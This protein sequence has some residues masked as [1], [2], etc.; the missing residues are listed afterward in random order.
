MLQALRAKRALTTEDGPEDPVAL[1]QACH[2][3]IRAFCA[4]ALAAATR[5][6]A[7]DEARIEAIDATERYFT[8]ALPLHVLDEEQSVLPRLRYASDAVSRALAQMESEHHAHAAALAALFAALARV[9][10]EPRSRS[11]R[12]ALAAVAQ[13]LTEAFEAHLR[14]EESLIFSAVAQLAPDE[15]AR[16]VEEIRARR[17]G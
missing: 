6:E 1:L 13:R 14:L 2:T 5:D 7:T 3:K 8:Q 10:V 15:R 12:D 11:A 17:R 9:R 16:I 4:L